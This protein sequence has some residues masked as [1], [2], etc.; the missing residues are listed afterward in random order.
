MRASLAMLSALLGFVAATNDWRWRLGGALSWQTDLRSDRDDADK[1]K[2]RCAGG[3]GISGQ[4]QDSYP[5]MELSSCGKN[6]VG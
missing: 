1:Q 4:D 2:A 3:S 6:C 5:E